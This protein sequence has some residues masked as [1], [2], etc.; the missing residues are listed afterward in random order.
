M[1]KS[2]QQTQANQREIQRDVEAKD[3]TKKAKRNGGDGHA[4][5][6]GARR[7]PEPPMPQQ[8]QRKPG[9]ESELAPQPMYDA[10]YYKGSGKLEGMIAIVTGG[11]SGI[12]RAVSVLYARE[13]ADIAV[14]YL[15]EDG[16]AEETKRA[17]EAEGRTCMLI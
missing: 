8:H 17:V 14:I 13:G 3:K 16:D 5:Q 7:Y 12:G 6:A 10:P 11:D 4:M 9:K 15:S 2:P 1:P